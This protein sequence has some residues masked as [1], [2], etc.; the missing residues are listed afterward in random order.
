MSDVEVNATPVHPATGKPITETDLDAEFGSEDDKPWRR[1]GTDLSDYFNYGFDEFTWASY[2]LKQQEVR[3]GITDQKKQ[4]EEMTAFLGMPMPGMPGM[5]G[6][7]M[8]TPASVPPPS[9]T[10]QSMVNPMGAVPGMPDI[11]PEVMQSMLT[12]MM[13][14]GVDPSTMDPMTLMQQAQAMMGQMSQQMGGQPGQ[15]GFGGQMAQ[16]MGPQMGQQMSQ[17][18]GQQIGQQ[19]GYGSFDQRGNY[20]PGMRGPGKGGRRW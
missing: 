18:M 1:P 20:G 17:Q 13:A 15:A 6:M 5:P 11:P 10:P 12:A 7:P 8:P 9:M 4:M 19:M 3:Q 2:C 14:Q 16:G